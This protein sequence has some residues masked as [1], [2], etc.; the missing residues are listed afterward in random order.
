M[1]TLS[2]AGQRGSERLNKCPGPVSNRDLNP[3]SPIWPQGPAHLVARIIEDA[4]TAN[5]LKK[6]K[7]VVSY[8]RQGKVIILAENLSN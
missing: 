6:K 8:M 3:A 5:K 7:N 2:A 4:N 1:I